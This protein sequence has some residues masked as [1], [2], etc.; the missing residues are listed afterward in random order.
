MYVSFFAATAQSP[1]R[2]FAFRGLVAFH[3]ILLTLTVAIIE[4]RPSLSISLLG[5]VMLITGIVEGALVIGWRLTQLPKTRALEFLLASPLHPSRIFLTELAM[6]CLR[7]FFVTISALPLLVLLWADKKIT[8]LDMLPMLTLPFVWGCLTGLLLTGWAYEPPW[9]RKWKERA[10]MLLVLVYLIVGV[11][12]GENLKAWIEGTPTVVRNAILEGFFQFHTLHPFAVMQRWLRRSDP[13]V[14]EGLFITQTVAVV[15]FVVLLI[16]CA[17]RFKGHYQDR[18]FSPILDTKDKKR[19]KVTDR[20]LSWWALKRVSEFS[21]KINLWL[22]GGFGLLYALHTMAGDYWPSWMGRQVFLVFDNSFGGVSGVATALVVLSAVP[23]AYQ[24]GLWDNNTQ[25]RCRRLELL[26]MTELD[27]HDY[28]GAAVSAAW[29]RGAGYFFIA[30]ILWI[31]GAI[32]GQLPPLLVVASV[33][34]S[35]VLWFLYFT[36]GFRAFSTGM[37]AGNLGL[38]LSAI[39]PLAAVGLFQGGFPTLAALTPPGSVYAMSQG[40]ETTAATIS[41]TLASCVIC[42]LQRRTLANCLQD[43]RDWYGRFHGQKVMD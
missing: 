32:G 27:A 10:M 22:A 41:I 14:W 29:R 8:V 3:L 21:G 12:A 35:V 33:A 1:T 20:P 15:G 43:L 31:S 39:I 42:F 9:F 30:V 37:Q 24:Y 34:A 5:I 23:A 2:Q 17:L 28:W 4:T 7:L 13:F 18:H 38:F 25:D 16:Q 26:L 19:P 11:L 40:M 6:G 36:L